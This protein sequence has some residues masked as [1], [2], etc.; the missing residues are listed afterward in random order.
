M[1]TIS[2]FRPLIFHLKIGK[3]SMKRQ[4]ILIVIYIVSRAGYHYQVTKICC[5][6]KQSETHIELCF[7][8]HP[9]LANKIQVVNNIFNRENSTHFQLNITGNNL[10]N[11]RDKPFQKCLLYLFYQQRWQL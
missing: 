1:V 11:P 3:T 2:F 5:Y 10:W 8:K 7:L 6:S 9:Y 4:Y